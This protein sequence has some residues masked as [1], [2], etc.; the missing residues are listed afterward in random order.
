MMQKVGLSAALGTFLAGV[1]LADSEYQ[2][3]L[4][5]N[6][7]PF[8]G[9]LMGLFFIAVGMSVNIDLVLIHPF[10]L[11]ATSIGY[12]LIKAG[13]I[14]G[15]GRFSKM[16]HQNSKMMALAIAQGGEFAFVIFGTIGSMGLVDS[17]VIEYLTVVITLSMALNPLFSMLNQMFAKVRKENP[18]Y[19]EIKDER[20]EVIIAGFGRFG[21]TFGR[22]LKAQGIRFVAIDHDSKQVDLVRNFGN[23]CYYGD[24]SRKGILEMAGAAQAKYFILAIDDVELSLKTAELVKENFP[25]LKIF[26]RARN[27]GH[28]FSLMEMGIENIKRETFDSSVNFTKQLLLAMGFDKE[29]AFRIIERF[30][31]HDEVM[32][33]EQF[34]VRTDDKTMISVSQQGVAQ[35][36]QVLNDDD[37]Q[38]HIE[39][40]PPK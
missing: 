1:L 2:H 24:A 18:E 28:A 7:E 35:L 11:V 38:T 40:A 23:Q 30:R 25:N 16:N 22:V 15:V 31:V 34:K 6:L 27:R 8:K 13:I 21:Q 14:Y 19:D 37:R 3:E 39:I 26:A 4:E 10:A 9:L 20:P 29:K 12:L 33:R 32:I 5:A 36:A 17:S